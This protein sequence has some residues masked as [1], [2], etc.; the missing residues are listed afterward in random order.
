MN[1]VE[2]DESKDY[3][4]KISRFSCMNKEEKAKRM[5][6]NVTEEDKKIHEEIFAENMLKFATMKRANPPSRVD[7]CALTG[8]VEDQQGCGSCWSFSASHALTGRLRLRDGMSAP[9]VRLSEQ[10]A[11]DCHGSACSGDSPS[12][13]WFLYQTNGAS[14]DFK[15]PYGGKD[16][17]AK[18]SQ[19]SRPPGAVKLNMKSG[20]IIMNGRIMYGDY[21]QNNVDE[22]KRAVAEGPVSISL[23]FDCPGIGQYSRGV[24]SAPSQY[25]NG[26]SSNHAIVV[27]GYDR[28]AATGKMYWRA[29]NS[30]GRDWG[31]N[32]YMK[33]EMGKNTCG[34]ES[35]VQVPTLEAPKT[36]SS[37]I[38][39]KDKRCSSDGDCNG[40]RDSCY[41]GKCHCFP[42]CHANMVCQENSECGTVKDKG[43]CAKGGDPA[44]SHSRFLRQVSDNR[45]KCCCSCTKQCTADKVCT[46]DFEC[47]NTKNACRYNGRY[48][49]GATRVYQKVCD[50]TGCQDTRSCS[51]YMHYKDTKV[52][53][54]DCKKS[55]GKC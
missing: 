38:C 49:T 51:G 24:Y 20:R 26:G 33:I 23:N 52:L 50:C 34:C 37:K 28:D 17:P 14:T 7:H 45:L 6:C 11:V 54:I 3:S 35:G 46:S 16:D 53:Q 22:M 15:Y 2:D 29:K 44:V 12:T 25:N 21:I 4:Q 42:T 31:D 48:Y 19:C 8:P 36:D 55:F 41:Q 5:G 9:I 43:V 10:Q 40:I 32:G 47:G 27:C 18:A 1:E 39:Q 30:Y 13:A